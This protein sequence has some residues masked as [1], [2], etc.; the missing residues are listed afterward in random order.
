MAGAI[1]Y[2]MPDISNY[3]DS[4]V[5]LAQQNNLWSAEQAQKQMD[6]QER[7]SNTSIQRAMA[8]MKAAGINPILSAQNGATSPSG[9]MAQTDTSLVTAMSNIL[10]KVM[11]IANDNAKAQ[12]ISQENV[13]SGKTSNNYGSSYGYGSAKTE[14]EQGETVT[15]ETVVNGFVDAISQGGRGLWNLAKGFVHGITGQEKQKNDNSLGYAVGTNMQNGKYAIGDTQ[16]YKYL[17]GQQ[18]NTSKNITSKVQNAMKNAVKNVSNTQ[19]AMYMK[20]K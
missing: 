2:S 7:M 15:G 3:A 12:L 11:D 20:K 9:A 18:S 14:E 10:T 1:M 16:A 19:A 8:D 4:M 5:H 17:N 13:A 6:F